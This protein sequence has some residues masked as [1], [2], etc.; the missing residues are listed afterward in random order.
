[1]IRFAPRSLDEAEE[2]QGGDRLSKPS[3]EFPLRISY[4]VMKC[5]ITRANYSNWDV[6][7][8]SFAQVTYAPYV[9]RRIKRRDTNIKGS[10]VIGEI[11]LEPIC[12][13]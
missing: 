9:A 2:L 3:S 4:C 13:L 12:A 11:N 10:G 1:M 5:E 6:Y 8:S 7:I